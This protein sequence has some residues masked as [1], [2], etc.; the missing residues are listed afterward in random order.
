MAASATSFYEDHIVSTTVLLS[1]KLG[2]ERKEVT[3]RRSD[4]N[5]WREGL[6]IRQQ[7]ADDITSN[8]KTKRAKTMM[9]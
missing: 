8:G 3:K 9:T 4:R 6:K 7:T 2:R 1:R 5:M